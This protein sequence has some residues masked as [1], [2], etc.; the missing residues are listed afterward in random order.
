MAVFK[1]TCIVLLVVLSLLVC[2]TLREAQT[3]RGKDVA[4]VYTF[5]VPLC[6]FLCVYVLP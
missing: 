6:L 5:Y 1:Y 3:C 4:D 2:V